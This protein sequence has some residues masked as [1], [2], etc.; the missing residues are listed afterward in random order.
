VPAAAAAVA[1]ITSISGKWDIQISNC[2]L[3]PDI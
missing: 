3:K 2:H 1:Q